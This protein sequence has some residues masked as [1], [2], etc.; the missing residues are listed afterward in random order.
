[1]GEEG[2]GRMASWVSGSPTK[3]EC[4]DRTSFQNLERLVRWSTDATVSDHWSSAS[5]WNRR[6]ISSERALGLGPLQGVPR[7]TLAAEMPSLPKEELHLARKQRHIPTDSAPQGCATGSQPWRQS[8]TLL[9]QHV[10]WGRSKDQTT[11]VPTEPCMQ[12]SWPSW[13]WGRNEA[14]SAEWGWR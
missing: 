5:A 13:C 4:R 7:W 12:A 3:R 11:L 10:A 14:D 9:P 1:M 2:D 6:D 8:W